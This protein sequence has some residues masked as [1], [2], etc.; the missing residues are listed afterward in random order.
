MP[1]PLN[2]G[3]EWFLLQKNK[4]FLRR[5]GLGWLQRSR[6]VWWRVRSGSSVSVLRKLTCGSRCLTATRFRCCA[7]LCRKLCLCAIV[8]QC[9]N[10]TIRGFY[11][12]EEAATIIWP[13]DMSNWLIW[14]SSL[15]N[16]T[17]LLTNILIGPKMFV[18]ETGWAEGVGY[19]ISWKNVCLVDRS[20]QTSWCRLEILI[21]YDVR[22][23]V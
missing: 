17:V 6:F 21:K 16:H 2:F 7:L 23:Q 14:C 20:A 9:S 5:S 12:I 4:K 13:Y 15:D 19:A 22:S 18:S 8:L 3:R 1:A 10:V 11:E